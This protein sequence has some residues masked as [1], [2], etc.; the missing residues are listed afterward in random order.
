MI[1]L[2][3]P[4][5]FT[6]GCLHC[7]LAFI[8]SFFFFFQT[9][10]GSYSYDSCGNVSW[11]SSPAF[12]KHSCVAFPFLPTSD[13]HILA[14]Q[15]SFLELG[16]YSTKIHFENNSGIVD[17]SSHLTKQTPLVT[18]LGTTHLSGNRIA[19]QAPLLMEQSYS[20]SL[21]GWC[22]ALAPSS[23]RRKVLRETFDWQG[24]INANDTCS[25]EWVCRESVLLS[26]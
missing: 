17:Q 16:K 10:R 21:V 1:S 20:L 8:K 9:S 7:R 14:A 25:L 5:L 22:R 3:E 19:P 11:T 2:S 12:S 4:S 26:H 15:S 24:Q 6:L 13:F 23:G 18:A